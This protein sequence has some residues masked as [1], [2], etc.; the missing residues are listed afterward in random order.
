[1]EICIMVVDD[2]GDDLA[3]F[4]EA[5]TIVKPDA[6]CS[7]AVDGKDAIQ[8]LSNS[9][10]K[11]PAIIFLDIN[12]P[13]MNGWDCISALKSSSRFSD[14][15]VVIYT[16]SSTPADKEK[17]IRM[18]AICFISKMQDFKNLKKMLE[19]VVQNVEKNDIDL[20]CAE[21]HKMVEV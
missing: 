20:I 6:I 15:P 1:M 12:M 18:G 7:L 11:R 8:Y 17:A 13:I 4:G 10:A 14:I 19:I 3:L 21:V 16:T 2:D 5:L 9:G